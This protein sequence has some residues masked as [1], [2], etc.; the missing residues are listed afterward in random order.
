M[1]AICCDTTN[2]EL[3]RCE[4]RDQT[5]HT[6]R[7]YKLHTFTHIEKKVRRKS[8]R[9]SVIGEMNVNNPFSQT[10]SCSILN[11]IKE[12]SLPNTYKLASAKRATYTIYHELIQ[13]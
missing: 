2:M 11:N 13:E 10:L 3:F 4:F 5:F 1:E 7:S 12:Q 8:A 6:K 9:N